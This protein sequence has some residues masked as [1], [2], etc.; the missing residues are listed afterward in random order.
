MTRKHTHSNRRSQSTQSRSIQLR[1]LW[2]DTR[3]GS[4]SQID[5]ANGM[6]IL[7]FGIIFFFGA[8]TV[9]LAG[10]ADSGPEDQLT[11]W[12]ISDKMVSDIFVEDTTES[13]PAEQCVTAFFNSASNSDCE[14]DSTWESGSEEDYLRESLSLG[15]NQRVAVKLVDSSGTVQQ[16][17]GGNPPVTEIGQYQRRIPIEESTD[18]YEWYT[19]KVYVW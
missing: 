4:A 10:M 5:F 15:D 8:S 14:H 11:S 7:L 2:Q 16:Q 3:G 12:R 9:V 19:L 18:T 17:T 1:Q 6:I 13:T